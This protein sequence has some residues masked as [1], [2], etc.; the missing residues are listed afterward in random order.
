MDRARS[1]RKG[2]AN[3]PSY[4]TRLT[5]ETNAIGTLEDLRETAKATSLDREEES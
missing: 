4:L 3:A 5:D 2:G 1:E